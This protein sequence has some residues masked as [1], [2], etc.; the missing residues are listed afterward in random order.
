[1]M[2]VLVM[3]QRSRSKNK[4]SKVAAI[5]KDD[6]FEGNFCDDG[7]AADDNMCI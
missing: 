5:Q 3:Q 2:I 4:K 1:M 6:T 7:D